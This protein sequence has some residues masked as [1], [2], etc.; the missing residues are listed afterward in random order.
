MTPA[1]S[2]SCKEVLYPL[3]APL[4]IIFSV[5]SLYIVIFGK[6]LFCVNELIWSFKATFAERYASCMLS[7]G[8]VKVP[9]LF[10]VIS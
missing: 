10:S 8:R 1:I 9:G 3:P 5:V 4:Y 6:K 2:K 7:F